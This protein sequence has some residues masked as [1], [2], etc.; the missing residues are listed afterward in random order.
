MTTPK[1]KN[2]QES[3][4]LET[5]KSNSQASS[6]ASP[7]TDVPA[8]AATSAKGLNPAAAAAE[9]VAP[10]RATDTVHIPLHH[11]NNTTAKLSTWDV[12]IKHTRE[13]EYVYKWGDKNRTGKV[14]RCNLVY[15]HDPKQYCLSEI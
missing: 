4:S 7:R 14:F 10:P 5:A 13:E 8:T 15:A 9:S 3:P 12:F 1:S 2:Q 6:A 11:L